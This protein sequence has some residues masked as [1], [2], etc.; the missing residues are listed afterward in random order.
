[1]EVMQDREVHLRKY[2]PPF[3]GVSGLFFLESCFPCILSIGNVCYHKDS[4]A[5]L[6]NIEELLPSQD[7]LFWCSWSRELPYAKTYEAP[8]R[9]K[10]ER[11]GI[12]LE[13]HWTCVIFSFASYILQHA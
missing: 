8:T 11:P 9:R 6:M 4:C 12:P 5:I 1:M 3:S 10:G 13:D 7:V 2:L